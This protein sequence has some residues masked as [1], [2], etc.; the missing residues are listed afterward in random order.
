MIHTDALDFSECHSRISDKILLT[1]SVHR[2][3]AQK[4]ETEI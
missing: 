3:K 2:K 1:L 4:I